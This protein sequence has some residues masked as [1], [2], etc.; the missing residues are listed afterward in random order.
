MKQ[1]SLRD[2][3]KFNKFTT[4]TEMMAPH[5]LS[6]CDMQAYTDVV[7]AGLDP[8]SFTYR[9]LSGVLR[10]YTTDGEIAYEY[11]PNNRI[12]TLPCVK[13]EPQGV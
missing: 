12:W 2:F 10:A 7:R 1:G 6:G 8:W 11:D 3:R 5:E 9:V 4:D 13:D